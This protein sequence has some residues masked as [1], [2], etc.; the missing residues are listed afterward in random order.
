MKINIGSDNIN[1]EGWAVVQV[2]E[3][4]EENPDTDKILGKIVIEVT[5]EKIQKVTPVIKADFAVFNRAIN[6]KDTGEFLAYAGEWD[7]QRLFRAANVDVESNEAGQAEINP[8]DLIGRKILVRL[9]KK[10]GNDGK[11]YTEVFTGY[12][13]PPDADKGLIEKAEKDFIKFQERQKK[14]QNG[15]FS[16]NVLNAAQSVASQPSPAESAAQEP[17]TFDDDIDMF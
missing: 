6:A 11:T 16:N 10:T 12:V 1:L 4:R 7:I 15:G 5:N 14:R 13:I 2:K 9:Y 17:A 3:A 8:A